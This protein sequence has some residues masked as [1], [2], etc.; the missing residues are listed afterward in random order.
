MSL[1]KR[2]RRTSKVVHGGMCGILLTVSFLMMLSVRIEARSEG[3][4]NLHLR[5]ATSTAIPF[6]IK[7]EGTGIAPAIKLPAYLKE[8]LP[9]PSLELK[10]DGE[11]HYNNTR[12]RMLPVLWNP[13]IPIAL[14]KLTI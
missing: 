5:E 10:L 12:Q 9:P 7:E 14:R 13:T 11:S 3:S 1:F 8:I 6:G 2:I 4:D